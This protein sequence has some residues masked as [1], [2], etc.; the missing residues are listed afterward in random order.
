MAEGAHLVVGL[1]AVRS[2]LKHGAGQVS[3]LA[4]GLLALVLLVL[5]RC[6]V[7]VRLWACACECV[8]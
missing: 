5:L 8:R 3:A 2:A 6:C 7:C 1:N 4:V